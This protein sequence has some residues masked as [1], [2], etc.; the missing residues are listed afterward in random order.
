MIQDTFQFLGACVFAVGLAVVAVLYASEHPNAELRYSTIAVFGMTPILFGLL[1]RQFRSYTRRV[2]FW[3][4][5]LFALGVH[6]TLWVSL[7]AG[8]ELK[9]IPIMILAFLEYLLL[10]T[11]FSLVFGPAAEP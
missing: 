4:G 7:V 10:V 8:S 6:V 11:L 1:L 5:Y 3:L 2:Q 9:A